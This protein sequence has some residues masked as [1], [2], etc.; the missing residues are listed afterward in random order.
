[1]R[2]TS[3]S[4]PPG[5]LPAGPVIGPE[6]RK[7]VCSGSPGPVQGD[8]RIRGDGLF[9]LSYTGGGVNSPPPPRE[10][11]RGER[12]TAQDLAVAFNFP[13]R[14]ACQASSSWCT[15]CTACL[16]MYGL[17][18]PP[19]NGDVNVSERLFPALTD[20]AR[21]SRPTRSLPRSGLRHGVA[22]RIDER[23]RCAGGIWAILFSFGSAMLV[24]SPGARMGGPPAVDAI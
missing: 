14:V 8:R 13:N 7:I 16:R 6:A 24:V 5:C 23:R 18:P 9:F 2:W 1:M 21:A 22:V 4:T 3:E 20:V 10:R 12:G 17:S 19:G 15:A 11:W